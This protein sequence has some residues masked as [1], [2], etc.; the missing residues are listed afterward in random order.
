M[1][2]QELTAAEFGRACKAFMDAM[3]A[4]AVPRRSPLQERIA[5][6]LGADAAQPGRSVELVGLGLENRRF[7][8]FGLSDLLTGRMALD[9]GPVDYV[10]FRLAD[11]QPLSC[12]QLGLYFVRQG[13]AQA[14][15]EDVRRDML[16]LN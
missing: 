15:L 13:D 5:A 12:V 9:E 2:D 8:A 4:A 1:P 7:M 14:F 6:H 16:R 10:N 3:L 11:D